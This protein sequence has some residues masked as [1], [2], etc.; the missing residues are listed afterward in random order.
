MRPNDVVA[1]EHRV[2]VSVP[3]SSR[4]AAISTA[5]NRPVRKS[6]RVGAGAASVAAGI[7]SM[8]VGKGNTQTMLRYDL[9]TG[10]R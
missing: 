5:T 10:E 3:G 7:G 2:Y 4:V 1:T 6:P 9:R 8:W